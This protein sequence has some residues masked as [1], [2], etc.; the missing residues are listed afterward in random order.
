MCAM[1]VFYSKE[2]GSA[3]NPCLFLGA[4]AACPGLL[5]WNVWDSPYWWLWDVKKQS[6]VSIRFKQQR[7]YVGCSF[8]RCELQNIVSSNTVLFLLFLTPNIWEKC[9]QIHVEMANPLMLQ[10]LIKYSVVVAPQLFLAVL[11]W[12]WM[13]FSN[14][15]TL[16]IFCTSAVALRSRLPIRI[17]EQDAGPEEPFV[18]SSRALCMLSWC[19]QLWWCRFVQHEINTPFVSPFCVKNEQVLHSCCRGEKTWQSGTHPAAS[20]WHSRAGNA[21][22]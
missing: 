11:F 21:W 2:P 12:S 1:Q 4:S 18:W 10:S 20:Q 14:L 15:Q 16:G 5:T 6:G 17:W 13:L 7:I 8:I 3:T 22:K 9:S 19:S